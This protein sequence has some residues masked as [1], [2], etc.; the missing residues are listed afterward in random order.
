MYTPQLKL[1]SSAESSS[2]P[3]TRGRAIASRSQRQPSLSTSQ[4]TTNTAH[5][6]MRWAMICSEGTCLSITQYSGNTPHST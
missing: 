5:Q 4:P 2:R 6:M 1:I 3:P